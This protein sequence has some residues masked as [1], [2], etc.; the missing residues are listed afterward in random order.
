M[1]NLFGY[2]I[3]WDHPDW[4][5]SNE[6]QRYLIATFQTKQQA[7]DYVEKARLRHTQATGYES[8]CGHE[9][10]ASSKLRHYRSCEIVEEGQEQE[11]TDFDPKK[12]WQAVKAQQEE[13]T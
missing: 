9:Y 7:E 12:I 4:K 6:Y 2:N 8:V 5:N 1:Y 11:K 13:R 10:R 3:T